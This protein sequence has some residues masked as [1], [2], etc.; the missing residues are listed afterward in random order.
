MYLKCECGHVMTDVAAPNNVEH[1][2]LSYS[3]KERLQD[4][5]DEEFLTNGEIDLWPEHWKEAGGIDVWKCPQCGRFQD[6]TFKISEF[7]CLR[8]NHDRLPLT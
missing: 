1:V 2:L 7:G 4:L 8:C 6:P 5:V 3:A